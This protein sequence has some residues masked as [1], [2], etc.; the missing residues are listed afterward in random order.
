MTD[1]YSAQP[2][3]ND[4]L[5]QLDELLRSIDPEQSMAV[6]EADGFF[7]ALACCPEP[8]A[9]EEFLPVV[10]GCPLADAHAKL[11]D[12][13]FDRLRRLLERQREAMIAQLYDDEGITPVLGYDEDERA[14]GN[15]WAIGFVRGMALRPEAWDAL[16]DDD[17]HAPALDPLMRLVAEVEPA[18][19][20]EP[21]PIAEDER[22]DLI[23]AMLE[24]VQSVFAFFAPARERALSPSEPVRRNE[25]KVGRNDPCPCG[26]GKK[27]KHCH[28]AGQ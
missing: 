26:S 14:T 18:D 15:A 6:E 7:A 9:P 4:D 2:I 27:Y 10:L 25:P 8:I 28:G 3:T 22:E 11:G 17:E 20:E 19:G 24:G 13:A 1:D 21:E 5:I 16:D 23:A 12:K